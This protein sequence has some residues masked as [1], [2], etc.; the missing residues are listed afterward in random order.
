MPQAIRAMLMGSYASSLSMVRV[1]KNH[2]WSPDSPVL[3]LSF[4]CDYGIAMD[5]QRQFPT[6]RD[7]AGR[8]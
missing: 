8:G 5:A 6:L 4:L 2:F 3:G 1:S 7:E